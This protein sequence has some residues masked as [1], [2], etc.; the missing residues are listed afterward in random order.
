MV[1]GHSAWL[2]FALPPPVDHDPID[3]LPL[4][5]RADRSWRTPEMD[6]WLAVLYQAWR[7]AHVPGAREAAK[8][9]FRAGGHEVGGFAWLCSLLNLDPVA[10]TAALITRTPPSQ[11]APLRP[12]TRARKR[13]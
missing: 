6:L 12:H 8:A 7:D 11:L 10:T 1:H 2:R 3:D 4:I 13:H 9:W 5:A